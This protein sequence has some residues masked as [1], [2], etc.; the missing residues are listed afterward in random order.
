MADLPDIPGG[1]GGIAAAIGAGGLGAVFL[2][3]KVWRWLRQEFRAETNEKL[4]E[5]FQNRTITRATEL[6]K[7]LK[8][9][10]NKYNEQTIA[11]GMAKGEL[12][13][14][15]AQLESMVTNKDYWKDRAHE[16][17]KQKSA[18]DL[19]LAD[20]DKTVDMLTLH[21]ANTQFRLAVARGELDPKALVSTPLALLPESAQARLDEI[22]A[23]ALVQE[24]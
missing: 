8:E 19:K 2:S 16:L 7:E 10:Q 21:L 6:E 3:M 9:L 23:S 13:A 18:L 15:K 1:T 20:L 17:E 24:K 22:R 12:S 4:Q 11:L 5:S 14:V